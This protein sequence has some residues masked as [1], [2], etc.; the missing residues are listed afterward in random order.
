MY[1]ADR[2]SWAPLAPMLQK[3]G[4]ATLAYDIR[5]TGESVKPA[6]KKLPDKYAQRDTAHFNGAWQDTAAAKAWLSKQPECDVERIALIGASIGCSIS[7]DYGGRD[8]AVKSIICLSPGTSYFGVDSVA[9][10]KKCTHPA[11]LL[12]SPREEYGEIEKLIEASGGA[13]KGLK[14]PGGR[15]HHGT[16]M[17]EQSYGERVKTLVVSHATVG[18]FQQPKPTTATATDKKR[19]LLKPAGTKH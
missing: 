1:P 18:L 6:D 11:I 4:I 14:F 12:L 7:L 3:A 5:G 10:I 9:A 13:A 17:L 16:K 8:T 2:K 15:E 19:H